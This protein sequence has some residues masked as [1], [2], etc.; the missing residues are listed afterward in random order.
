MTINV[1]EKVKLFGFRVLIE[2]VP[3]KTGTILVPETRQTIHQLGRVVVVGDCKC[4]DGT[5]EESLVAVGDLVYFQTNA[6]LAQGQAYEAN[7]QSYLNLHQGDLI[8]RLTSTE[9]CYPNFEPLGRWV[10]IEPFV[11]NESS[12]IVLP[13]A[14]K[15][16]PSFVYFKIAKL[17]SRTKLEAKVGHEVIIN[18]GRCNAVFISKSPSQLTEAPGEYGYIDR[19]FVLGVIEGTD[20]PAP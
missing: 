6:V 13:T 17:G 5:Q 1:A 9:I 16:N 19:D 11:R 15:E 7:G 18:A 14:A 3:E 8:A 4:P 20:A 10:L 12:I 2:R